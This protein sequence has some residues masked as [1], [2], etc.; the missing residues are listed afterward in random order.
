[1]VD[2][3]LFFK[4]S[5]FYMGFNG[6]WQKVAMRHRS[7]YT[8][9]KNIYKIIGEELALETF[10]SIVLGATTNVQKNYQVL[11]VQKLFGH[12]TMQPL[13]SVE[14]LLESLKHNT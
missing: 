6:A 5:Y 14:N 8:D 2:F 9:F 10:Y 7:Q 12:M 13:Y 3:I 4:V 1:M 11:G